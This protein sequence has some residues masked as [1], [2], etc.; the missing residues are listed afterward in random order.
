M[1]S[2]NNLAGKELKMMFSPFRDP[3]GGGQLPQFVP[4]GAP[5]GQPAAQV[6][7]VWIPNHRLQGRQH[8]RWTHLLPSQN[9]WLAAEY[10]DG[11]VHDWYLQPSILKAV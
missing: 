2:S 10:T 9:T 3:P 7:H 1:F 5:S 11:L 6:L 8:Q 4:F